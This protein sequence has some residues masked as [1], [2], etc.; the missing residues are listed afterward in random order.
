MP[1]PRR[2]TPPGMSFH[3][4]NRGNEK[5]CLF[6]TDKDFERFLQLLETSRQRFAVEYRAYCLMTNHWHLVMVGGTER[7]ISDTIQWVA[8]RHACDLRR[9]EGSVGHGHVYQSRFHSFPIGS[10]RH[11]L[12]VMRYVEA[13][14]IRAHLVARAEDWRWSSLWDRPRESR[15][16]LDPLGF[17]LPADWVEIV[18]TPV[19]TRV[20]QRI[21]ESIQQGRPYGPAQ[22]VNKTEAMLGRTATT[23]IGHAPVDKQKTTRQ[24]VHPMI[25]GQ[26]SPA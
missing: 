4:L 15:A 3:V 21:K 11:L 1:R 23:T 19:S 24:T 6:R 25:R 5:R 26:S 8:C 17:E 22:W 10:P 13:N 14:P 2:I 20:A 18:N 16:I 9:R 12:N 7:A